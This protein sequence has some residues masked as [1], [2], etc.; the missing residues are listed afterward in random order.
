LDLVEKLAKALIETNNHYKKIN[1][2]SKK[3]KLDTNSV[4]YLSY[5]IDKLDDNTLIKVKKIIES[6]IK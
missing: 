2:S 3:E 5:L 4:D 6:I 1:T